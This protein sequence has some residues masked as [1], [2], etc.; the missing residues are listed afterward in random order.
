MTT[1][2][3]TKSL[4]AFTHFTRAEWAQLNDGHSAP[5]TEKSGKTSK[6]FMKRYLRQK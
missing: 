1:D 3:L 4:E 2:E 5:L 6:G